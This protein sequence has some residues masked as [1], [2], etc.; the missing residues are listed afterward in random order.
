MWL[1]NLNIP[2]GEGPH[3]IRLANHRVEAVTRSL[4][5]IPR[6]SQ[7]AYV[8]FDNAIV[9]PGLINS[10]DHL[11]F[12]LFPMIGNKIYA[13]YVDWGADI[14]TQNKELIRSITSIPRQLSVQWGIFKNIL[15]GVT[16]VVHHGDKVE[17]RNSLVDIKQDDQSIHSV[18]RGI[19]WR[20][21]LIDPRNR[22]LPVAIH[23]G[24]GTDLSMQKEIDSLL[25]W[26][27]WKRPL[28]GIHGIG[29]TEKQA[30]AFKA[31]VWCPVSNCFLYGQTA[32]VEK[33]GRYTTILFGSDSTLTG[34][35][36][37]WDHLRFARS[38]GKVSDEQL[39]DMVTA[40]AA[41]AWR[42]NK[43]KIEQH[44]SADIVVAR[45]PRNTNSWDDFYN[46][47]PRD[48]LLVMGKG[49]PALVDESVMKLMEKEY[50]LK[51]NYTEVHI[52][53]TAKLIRGNAR[54]LIREIHQYNP[55]LQFPV[56]F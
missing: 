38:T 29:M 5:S 13:N 19:N 7:E 2:G 55:E 27:L 35:W 30:A 11:D 21:Q 32:A 23:I 34:S 46:I 50:P 25:R 52:N 45:M 48:L 12:S 14:H 17:Q 15:S 42:L 4:P 36:N 24:E 6:N 47:N 53:G 44:A 40:R 20:R 33:L 3:H 54:G 39:Y 31:L 28:I 1:L 56:S 49:M 9:F 51:E 10:H 41:S 43:G 8:E 37:F 22:K 26:N 16:T 18:M